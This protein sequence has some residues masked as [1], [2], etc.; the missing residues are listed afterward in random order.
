[1]MFSRYVEIPRG[2]NESNQEHEERTWRERMYINPDT[3]KLFIPGMAFKRSLDATAKLPGFKRKGKRFLSG[4]LPSGNAE[5]DVAP[6]KAER[7]SLCV[8]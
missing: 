6:D 1:M 2:E 3:G 4:V 5:L 8:P 7:H